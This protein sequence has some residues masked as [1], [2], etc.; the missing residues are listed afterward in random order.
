[1]KASPADNWPAD[2]KACYDSFLLRAQERSGSRHTGIKYAQ[3]IRDFFALYPQKSPDEILQSEVESYL[4]SHTTGNGRAGRSPSPGLQNARLSALTSMYSY[5]SK[6]GIRG[7]DGRVY[8]L[9]RTLAPTANIRRVSEARNYKSLAPDEL[10][11]LFATMDQSTERG[12]R[13]YALFSTLFYTS[14]RLQEI[15]SLRW[16]DI[17]EVEV[18]EDGQTYSIHEFGFVGKGTSRIRDV[19]ELPQQSVAAIGRYLSFG[20]RID[21]IQPEDPIFLGN[22]YQAHPRSKPR[23]RDL[24]KPLTAQAVW[25]NLHCYGQ[26]AKLRVPIHPHMLRHSSARLRYL[27]GEKLQD[28]QH[29]LKHRNISTTSAYIDGICSQVDHGSRLLAAAVNL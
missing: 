13:D 22:A 29:T 15:L 18:Q 26:L 9:L 7:E 8:A 4:R 23:K 25:R 16:G 1:M 19:Q 11:R 17:S 2:W 12:A 14:R 6:Y 21:A 3:I 5:S 10:T 27:N 28:I 24:K 20:G